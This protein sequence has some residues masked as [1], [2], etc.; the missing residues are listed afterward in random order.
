M[1][2][3]QDDDGEAESLFCLYHVVNRAVAGGFSS[4]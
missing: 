1:R 2:N 4:W 3:Q